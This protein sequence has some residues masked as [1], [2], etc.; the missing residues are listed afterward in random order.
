MGLQGRDCP[1][2]SFSAEKRFYMF[3]GFVGLVLLVLLEFL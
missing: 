2:A 3:W 1:M